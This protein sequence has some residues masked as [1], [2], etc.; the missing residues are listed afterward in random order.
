MI[1][2]AAPGPS[3]APPAEPQAPPAAPQAPPAGPQ[4]PPAG[5][6]GALAERT[7]DLQRLKAEYDNYR[8]RVHRDRLAVREAAVANVLRRFLPVFD[9]LA[10]AARQGELTGGFERVA[11]AL[12][13]EAAALGLR[14][15]GAVGDPFDPR[16]HQAVAYRRSRLVERPVCT[17][18]VRPG[19]RVGDHL[20]RPAD[21]T[22]T[23]PAQG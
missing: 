17:E 4:T 10:E 8:G 21:V 6:A 13:G 3:A 9:A 22:V 11:L 2:P 19:Y 15:F 5:P 18:I 20:L 1:A 16:V 14:A 23:G 12:D 7:A